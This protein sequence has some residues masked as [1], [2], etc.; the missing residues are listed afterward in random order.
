MPLSRATFIGPWAGLP[1]AWTD[2]DRFDEAIYRAD[3][4]R[5]CKAGMPGVYTRGTTGEFYAMEFDEFQEIARATIEQCHAFATPAMIGCT[6][7]YTRG[8]VRRAEFAAE[9]GADA[10]QLAL[11]YWLA[12]ANEQ[13]IPFFVTWLLPAT[14]CPFRFTRRQIQS[15]PYPL[16][17]TVQFTTPCQ[18]F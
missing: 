9:M 16:I 7:T 11:P 2:D 6:S 3:L 13:I 5:C 1:V 8:A 12:I 10:I 14:D 18:V 4:T 15:V 17:S